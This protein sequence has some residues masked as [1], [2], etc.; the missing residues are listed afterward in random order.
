MSDDLLIHDTVVVSSPE[1]KMGN[2]KPSSLFIIKAGRPSEIWHFI[3]TRQVTRATH[4]V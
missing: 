3:Q 1:F 2:V 4:H